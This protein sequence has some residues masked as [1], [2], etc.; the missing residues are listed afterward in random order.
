MSLEIPRLH[1]HQG[2]QGQQ[3]A[4]KHVLEDA[5]PGAGHKGRV[6]RPRF[7]AAAAAPK[8]PL[9]HEDC[10][11]VGQLRHVLHRAFF[12]PEDHEEEPVH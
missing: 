7:P 8:E 9:G 3:R 2:H 11:L 12:V 4:Q 5:K 6:H 10:M 1:Q